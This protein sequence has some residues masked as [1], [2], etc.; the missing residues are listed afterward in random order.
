MEQGCVCSYHCHKCPALD[1]ATLPDIL[2]DSARRNAYVTWHDFIILLQL[3]SAA[4]YLA[5]YRA[6]A[7][8]QQVPEWC[9]SLVSL[10]HVALYGHHEWGISLGNCFA[11]CGNGIT[12]SA[13]GL[14]WQWAK[15]PPHSKILYYHPPQHHFNTELNLPSQHNHTD[16]TE[17]ECVRACCL[18]V[19]SVSGG[20]G[21]RVG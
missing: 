4:S 12:Q 20:W 8:V 11:L 10:I 14:E 7:E 5:E 6:V 18:A 17:L 3:S 2:G 16:R 9:P 13:H 15:N 19:F 21:K 1:L